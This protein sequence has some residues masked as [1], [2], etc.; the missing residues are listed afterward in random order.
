ML[1]TEKI[2]TSADLRSLGLAPTRPAARYK[3]VSI[4]RVSEK[5]A[6]MKRYPGFCWES[7]DQEEERPCLSS[8]EGVLAALRRGKRGDAVLYG[9]GDV[10]HVEIGRRQAAGVTAKWFPQDLQAQ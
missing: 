1:G 7:A 8:A 5:A 4:G 3:R 6:R 9:H 10:V 2:L